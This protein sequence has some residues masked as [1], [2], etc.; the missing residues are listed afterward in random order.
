MPIDK[1]TK[2]YI[3]DLVI[4][5]KKK[6]LSASS[7]EKIKQQTS[8][9]FTTAINNEKCKNN[10]ASISKRDGHSMVIEY[11]NLLEFH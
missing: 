8:A 11:N 1:I 3:N 5:L 7:I 4:L 6:N 2:K 10:S 9:T